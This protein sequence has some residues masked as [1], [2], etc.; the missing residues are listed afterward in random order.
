MILFNFIKK[1]LLLIRR[2][3]HALLVLFIMPVLFI[4]I[5][6]FALKNSFS[7]IIDHKYQVALLA[8][9]NL[10]ESNSAVFDIV[11]LGANNPN[12]AEELLYKQGF[13]FIIKISGNKRNIDMKIKAGI[14]AQY[15]NMLKA[16]TALSIQGEYLQ[17][18]AALMGAND[19]PKPIFYESHIDRKG[20]VQTISSVDHSVPSWLIFSMFFILIPIANTFMNEKAFGTLSR[21]KSMNISWWTVLLGKFIPYLLLNQIQLIFIL[22]VGFFLLPLLGLDALNVRGH[23]IQIWII[24]LF[25]S[26]AAIAFGLLIANIAK[27]SEEATTLGGISNIIFAALG[28]IMVPKTVMPATMQKI[29]AF[30]PM[31]WSLDSFLDTIMGRSDGIGNLGLSM[32]KLMV[33]AL[34]CLLLAYTLLRKEEH[35]R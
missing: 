35:I 5:M 27:S 32:L 11:F 10:A 24:A 8:E 9:K 17:E 33:F 31:S 18:I 25:T 2:D 22:A 6:S 26:I 4:V 30:S 14:P 16:E 34:V 12:S 7:G 15:V 21:L 19:N 23:L 28:G 29:S 1:E 20:M 13:D 3:I